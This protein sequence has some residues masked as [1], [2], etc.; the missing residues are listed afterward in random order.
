[1]FQLLIIVKSDTLTWIE[2]PERSTSN[3]ALTN[4]I[5]MLSQKKLVDPPSNGMPPPP[6]STSSLP[7]PP[8]KKHATALQRKSPLMPPP[9]S[10]SMVSPAATGCFSDSLHEE[11]HATW[12]I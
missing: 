1:M 6:R 8:F 9:P 11:S 5:T 3:T 12:F 7:P 10:R 4:V 2:F